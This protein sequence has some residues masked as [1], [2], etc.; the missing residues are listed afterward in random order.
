VYSWADQPYSGLSSGGAVTFASSVNDGLNTTVGVMQRQFQAHVWTMSFDGTNNWFTMDGKPTHDSRSQ[1]SS[2]VG[3]LMVIATNLYIGGDI[4]GGHN[5]VGYI[6]DFRIY[7]NVC[8]APFR[9]GLENYLCKDANLLVNSLNLEGDSIAEGLHPNA[10]LGTIQQMLS[11]VFP[12]WLFNTEAFSGRL[13]QQTYTNM[14]QWG[15]S[16]PVGNSVVDIYVGVNDFNNLSGVNQSNQVHLTLSS[17]T[18]IVSTALSN[19]MPVIVST[20]LSVFWETNSLETAGFNY[21]WRSNL[22]VGIRSL[23]NL[24]AYVCDYAADIPSMGTNGAYANTIDFNTDEVHPNSTGYGLMTNVVAPIFQFVLNNN[25]NL[26]STTNVPP[27]SLTVPLTDIYQH[28][29]YYNSNEV[30]QQIQ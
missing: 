20:L 8:T 2:Q 23:T 6:S 5:F 10:P 25:P 30:W 28:H 19:N 24:G 11:P 3:G 17:M 4:P 21:D 12:N 14:L 16:R 7:T 26:S 1:P 18:N 29:I 13:S 22:N 15:P 9:Q 27:F